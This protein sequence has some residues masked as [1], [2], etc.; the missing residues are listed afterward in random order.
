MDSFKLSDGSNLL[1]IAYLRRWYVKLKDRID[2]MDP[3]I[4]IVLKWMYHNCLLTDTL[5]IHENMEC[6]KLRCQWGLCQN[7]ACDECSSPFMWCPI[8][9]YCLNPECKKLARIHSL[10]L[11]RT[12]TMIGA[13][14][15]DPFK[16][17]GSS[18]ATNLWVY[19]CSY[20]PISY[21]GYI[22]NPYGKVMLDD[23]LDQ[24]PNAKFNFSYQDN[25]VWKLF[26][27][28]GP[29]IAFLRY[30][31]TLWILRVARFPQI[32]SMTS[33]ESQ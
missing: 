2:L 31:M 12:A 26:W 16:L 25:D 21:V 33:I 9:R 5:K 10:K 22:L 27:G 32:R 7:V 24:N 30:F 23:F 19:G 13:N 15:T 17:N 29:P 28:G 1:T 11:G 8:V 6:L 4:D 20:D 3:N 18:V 14:N